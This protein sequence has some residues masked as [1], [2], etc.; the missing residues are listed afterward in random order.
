MFK[1]RLLH[2]NLNMGFFS[3]KLLP[4]YIVGAIASLHHLTERDSGLYKAA[5]CQAFHSVFIYL[6]GLYIYSDIHLMF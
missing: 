2:N 4:N 1:T 6:A 5:S 3:G